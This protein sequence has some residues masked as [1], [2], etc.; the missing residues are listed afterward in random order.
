MDRRLWRRDLV[1]TPSTA[2]VVWGEALLLLRRRRRR[3]VALSLPPDS[4]L[5]LPQSPPASCAAE[6]ERKEDEGEEERWRGRRRRR[7]RGEEFAAGRGFSFLTSAVAR[8]GAA[9]SPFSSF[10]G[11]SGAICVAPSPR[12]ARALGTSDDIRRR[13]IYEFKRWISSHKFSSDII[14][15]LQVSVFRELPLPASLRAQREEE[16]VKRGKKWCAGMRVPWVEEGPHMLY[17]GPSFLAGAAPDPSSLP[18]PS[19]GPPRR[20]TSSSGGG[21]AVRVALIFL[22]GLVLRFAACPDAPAFTW[23]TA[24]GRAHSISMVR[25]G[26]GAA[27]SSNR[28]ARKKKTY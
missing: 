27:A 24:V 25:V 21:V 4:R 26:E 9:P 6:P 19:F 1:P 7:Q 22:A 17:A 12:R 3:I 8:A 10:S 13:R 5:P 28:I 18:I 11:R 15:C 23:S 2:T 14:T 20:R 16:E